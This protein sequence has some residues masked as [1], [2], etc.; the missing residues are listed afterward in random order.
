MPVR[1]SL[2]RHG[3][4]GSRVEMGDRAGILEGA[5]A[6]NALLAANTRRLHAAEGGAQVEAG[7]AVVV[8][9]NITADQLAADSI[10]RLGI[11]RPDRT[12]QARPAVVRHTDGCLFG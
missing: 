7:G 9:P 10:G 3:G 6:F 4:Q 12:A 8:D 11:G 1:T 5:D 2:V